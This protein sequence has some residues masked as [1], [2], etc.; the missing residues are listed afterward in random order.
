VV[1]LRQFLLKIEFQTSTPS[2][3]S[4]IDLSQL[5]SRCL[6]M[7]RLIYEEFCI[8]GYNA[9]Q[10]GKIQGTFQR[11]ISLIYSLLK[12]KSIKK[13]ARSRQ[14][15]RFLAY[16]STLNVEVLHSS[17]TSADLTKWVGRDSDGLPAERPSFDFRQR[18]DF[19]LLHRI[20]IGSEAYPAIYLIRTWSS[21]PGGK[22]RGA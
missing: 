16:F 12:I 17:G 8:P 1:A 21:L 9:E 19:S 4:Q 22:A 13:L 18:Q 3:H 5:Q 14:N 7:N 20:Q 6:H 11:N 2:G 10:S 15:A